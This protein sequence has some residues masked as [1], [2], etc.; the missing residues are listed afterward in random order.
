MVSGLHIFGLAIGALLGYFI[1]ELLFMRRIVK[2]AGELIENPETRLLDERWTR[3]IISA[4]LACGVAAAGAKEG[5]IRVGERKLIEDR[6]IRRIGIT[7]REAGLLRQIIDQVF[8]SQ[9]ADSAKLSIV[10]RTVSLEEERLL[11]LGLLLDVAAGENGRITAEQND[12]LKAISVQLEIPAEVYNKLRR[13]RITV[14]TDAY[15][16]IGLTPEA[17]DQEIHRVY[18]QL[19][20]QFHPDTGGDLD[21]AQREQAGEAF[22]RIQDAYR[23]IVAD[24]NAMR[25]GNGNGRP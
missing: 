6:I 4:A 18:R 3:I 5:G 14:D 21:D 16:I 15:E 13:D 17:S 11:L 10:F 9:E 8:T 12:L 1:D 19:A 7:G 2:R 23:R 24:R 20:A 25:S 22:L